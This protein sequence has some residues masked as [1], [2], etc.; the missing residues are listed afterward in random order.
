MEGLAM[1]LFFITLI[2]IITTI[3]LIIY[4]AIKKNFKYRPKQLAIVLVIFIVAFIGST[5][6]YGAV[7]S[8]ESKAKFEASQKAKEEE[9][10]QKELAEKEKKA[11][12]EKQKQENQQVKENSEA[13][14][15]T[16]QKEETPVVAE[17]PKVDDRFIIKS[18]PN[19]SAAVDELLKRG[20]EDSKNTTDSQIKEA[21]KFIN[22]NYY[23]NYWANN[24]IMEKTIYY[25]SLL[26]HSNSNKDIISLGT[27]AEQVVKY[28]YRGAEK[29]AD[30]STQSN[31]KQIKKSLEKIP[32]DYK[33]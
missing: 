28:I 22:D 33:K 21:V 17:V 15:E 3:V 10:A 18:E 2:G 19:T 7:Q 8:P 31:L 32:D 5:I 20:K 30:T 1:I 14:V 27:D 29:V 23:N 11:N 24:S 6:F 13:T 9:K 26:E 16:V 25:G 12:E 4:S